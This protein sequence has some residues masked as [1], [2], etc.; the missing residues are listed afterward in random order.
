MALVPREHAPSDASENSDSEPE[1]VYVRPQNDFDSNTSPAHSHHEFDCESSSAPS[2]ASSLE[3]LNLDSSFD[4]NPVDTQYEP[5]EEALLDT[6]PLTP[7]LQEIRQY[8]YENIPS[9]IPSLPS[10]I[11]SVSSIPA[12]S[13]TPRLSRKTRSKQPTAS[14]AKKGKTNKEESAIDVYLEKSA[15]SP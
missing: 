13:I 11:P 3:N 9:N 5:E 15:I 1:N 10:N 6:V 8:N 7:I 12:T 14:A 2:I 4:D